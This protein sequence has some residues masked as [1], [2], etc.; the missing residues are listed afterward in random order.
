MRWLAVLVL[1]LPVAIAC[2]LLHAPEWTI[3]VASAVSLLPLAAWIG[4]AT[5][6][7]RSKSIK[8]LSH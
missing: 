7:E 5:E 4:L 3:F 2:R 1:G 8:H 6:R